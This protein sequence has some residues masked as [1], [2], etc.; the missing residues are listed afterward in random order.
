[1]DT[2]QTAWL[3]RIEA[4]SVSNNQRVPMIDPTTWNQFTVPEW[5]VFILSWLYSKWKSWFF[6]KINGEIELSEDEQRSTRMFKWFV[7]MPWDTI[8]VQY[9]NS[10][11][12]E[13]IVIC[14]ELFLK[15][16]I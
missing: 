2:L 5:H 9:K 12:S 13:D 7:C 10:K 1:M 11:N 6:I 15:A 16:V 14:W 4:R 3:L 8:E